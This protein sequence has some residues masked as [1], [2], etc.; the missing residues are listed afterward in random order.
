MVRH[1]G[2]LPSSKYWRELMNHY[3]EAMI[4]HDARPV[5]VS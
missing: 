4:I 1:G 2:N 3:T 5:G